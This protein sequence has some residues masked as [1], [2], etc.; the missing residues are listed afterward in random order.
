MPNP[1]LRII[2][3]GKTAAVGKGVI[4]GLHPEIEVTRFITSLE[5]ARR[6][7]PLILSQQHSKLPT[8]AGETLGTQNFNTRPD[9]VMLGAGF[10]LSDVE[11]LD[12]EDK[13]PI[14][15]ADRDKP[16]PSLASGKYGE[17]ILKRAKDAL[18]AWEKDGKKQ[19]GNPIWF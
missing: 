10:S 4:A 9:A 11:V 14:F 7:I 3:C 2:L 17:A 16:A 12:K 15:L 5:S 6:E 19:Q 13:I 18:L 1:L 8:P